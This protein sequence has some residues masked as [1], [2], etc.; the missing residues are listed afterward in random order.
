MDR[1]AAQRGVELVVDPH[2]Q[3]LGELGT[4]GGVLAVPAG[5][6]QA[7]R[8]PGDDQ[9]SD[10]D[11]KIKSRT[12]G[13]G[14]SRRHSL[15]GRLG[16][17]Q[18]VH[19]RVPAGVRVE[20]L[21]LDKAAGPAEGDRRTVDGIAVGVCYLH[22]Q[23]LRQG[24][25]RFDRL[26]VAA[27]QCHFGRLAEKEL[28]PG[29]NPVKPQLGPVEQPHP[30]IDAVAR[31]EA[32]VLHRFVLAEITVAVDD[33]PVANQMGGI[34]HMAAV[35]DPY[36]GAETAH[37]AARSTAGDPEPAVA[38]AGG[39]DEKVVADG[40]RIAGTDR[41]AVLVGVGIIEIEVAVVIDIADGAAARIERFEAQAGIVIAAEGAAPII[42]V[43]PGKI[44]RERRDDVEVAVIVSVEKDQGKTVLGDIEGTGDLGEFATAVVAV[45][46]DF[47]VFLVFWHDKSVIVAVVVVIGEGGAVAVV[48]GIGVE[49]GA[50]GVFD[51]V[52]GAVP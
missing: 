46:P 45:G 6:G 8:N 35:I 26:V 16:G 49:S 30:D 27:H 17:R 11:R 9:G 7:G 40:V 36:L 3:R 13:I 37:V 31:P 38:G 25:A 21:G 28:A 34:I 2:L 4:R 39:V 12:R 29:R 18:I 41:D 50:A 22:H 52:A 1:D 42:A 43:K 51:K 33:L 10:H 48:A 32:K 15:A 5:N 20:R 47:S 23:G 19:R 14:T 24:F 44:A